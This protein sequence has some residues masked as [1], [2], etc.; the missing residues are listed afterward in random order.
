MLNL[1]KSYTNSLAVGQDY[2][3]FFSFHHILKN[4]TLTSLKKPGK[5]I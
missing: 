1:D 4:F 3:K 5:S 2:F